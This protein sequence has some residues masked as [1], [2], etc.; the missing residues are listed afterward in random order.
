M[1]QPPSQQNVRTHRRTWLIVISVVII[2]VVI[3][4]LAYFF[5]SGSH[6]VSNQ[7]ITVNI[8]GINLQISYTGLTSGYLGPTS[9]ALS[10]N[11]T[12]SGGQQFSFTITLYSSA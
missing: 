11:N 8:T 10:Y 6:Q 7:A 5:N 12:I 4:G 1:T 9:Q 2:V 3:I